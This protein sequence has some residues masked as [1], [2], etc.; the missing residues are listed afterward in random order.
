MLNFKFYFFRS[1]CIIFSFGWF[2]IPLISQDWQEIQRFNPAQTIQK[3]KFLN[4]ELGYCV[5]SL[6][7]GSTRNIHK[8]NNGGLSWESQN[9][10]FT[11]MRFMD[12]FIL[13]E[14]TTWICGNAG[15]ILKT[16]DG[17]QNWILKNTGTTEQIWSIYFTDA[18][19][20]F[21]CGSTGLL[22][23]TKDGGDS[24]DPIPS[25]INNLL[26]SM[27]FVNSSK[28]FAGGSNVLL[29]TDD[30]GE[31]WY[32]ENAFPFS[33]PGDWIRKILFV[34]ENVG[35]ACA[36]IG[37]IYKTLDGGDHWTKLESGT[38]EALMEI[39]FANENV[40]VA[41]GFN[42]TILFTKDGGAKWDPMNS[43][44]GTD[45]LFTVDLL[46]PQL[47]FIASHQGRILKN[48]LLSVSLSNPT[49]DSDSW[50]YQSHQ[51]LY[52]DLGEYE[53]FEFY[54][55][56][57]Q[58]VQLQN[59]QKVNSGYL[60]SLTGITPGLYIACKSKFNNLTCLP[61]IIY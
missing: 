29:R 5:S 42:G 20:G 45:H 13:D 49:K 17:G 22:L 19:N 6:Y 27:H 2:M 7:N 58:L 18:L 26:Y 47:G 16:T 31:T 41:V 23:R 32:K 53:K 10:G 60:F 21:A 50:L 28:G 38:Q 4:S 54:N 59:S 11:S 43:P 46:N 24:W 25:G 61:C 12:I 1:L 40:G 37:R 15:I 9:S 57:G 14:Q 8:T 3:I 33:P 51:S 48:D 35:Y 52:V 44:L 34:N 30:A 36:D 55:P 39:D 56:A